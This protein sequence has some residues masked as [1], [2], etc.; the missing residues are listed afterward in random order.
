MKLLVTGGCGFIG[1]NFIRLMLDKHPDWSVVNLDKLTYAGNRLN[2]LNLE[3]D[4][5]RYEFIQG[6]ICDRDLVMDLLS[7]KPNRRGGQLCRR[8]PCGPFH[9]RPVALR[10]HQRERSAKSHGV[11]PPMRNGTIRPCVHGRGVRDAG[12]NRKIYGNDSSGPELALLRQ[13]GRSGH[14]GPRLFRDLRLSGVG[15]PL[16]QQLRSLPIPG[17]ADPPHV[18]Q[19]QGGQAPARLRRRHERAGLDIRRRPLPRRGADPDQR[20]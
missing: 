4:D 14:D 2:L 20:A 5:N 6:D 1:T 13:Q 10:D 19:R 7:P 18:P 17:K 16:L 9:R 3:Q 12:Q 8:V 11:R 15:H